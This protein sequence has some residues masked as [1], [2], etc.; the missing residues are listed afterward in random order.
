MDAKRRLRDK[1]EISSKKLLV[2]DLKPTLILIY[3]GVTTLSRF[4]VMIKPVISSALLLIISLTNVFPQ[5]S[6]EKIRIN[7]PIDQFFTD[8]NWGDYDQDG[9]LDILGIALLLTGATYTSDITLLRN[10]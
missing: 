1:R 6:F 2:L 5:Q 10:D 8:A 7:T 9:D 3:L 4:H